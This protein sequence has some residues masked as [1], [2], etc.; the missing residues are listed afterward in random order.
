M[1]EGEVLLIKRT[2]EPMKNEWWL[3][4]GRLHRSE[5]PE[6]CALRKVEEETGLQGRL[7]PLIHVESTDFGNVHSV[8]LVYIMRVKNRKV[9][10]NN[11]SHGAVWTQRI[12]PHL[13]PYIKNSLSKAGLH[14]V[15]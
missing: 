6:Q 15:K 11:L 10:E 9:R 4:G 8:N 5:T 7:G 12:K 3:P 13:H 1:H 14:Y 2:E